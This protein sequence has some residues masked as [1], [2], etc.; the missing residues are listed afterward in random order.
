M[1]FVMGGVMYVYVALWAQH[2]QP[3]EAVLMRRVVAV[4]IFTVGLA[5]FAD[6]VPEVAGPFALMLI[7]A[8]A[9]RHKGEIGKVL[10]RAPA[11]RKR[12]G[13]RTVTSQ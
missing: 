8:L 13:T 7:V 11:G 3:D 6:F 1:V 12:G 5:T 2:T 10:G 4:G 9:A